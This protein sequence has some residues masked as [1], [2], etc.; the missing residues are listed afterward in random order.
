MGNKALR[1]YYRAA[2]LCFQCGAPQDTLAHCCSLCLEKKRLYRKRATFARLQREL[3]MAPLE[4]AHNLLAE[5]G[6]M[7]QPDE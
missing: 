1:E 3:E 5:Q 6:S 2:K 4:L 7:P